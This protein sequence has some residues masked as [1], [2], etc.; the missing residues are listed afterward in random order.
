MTRQ[1]IYSYSNLEVQELSV[2]QDWNESTKNGFRLEPTRTQELK[3]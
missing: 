3:V 1:N 2:L